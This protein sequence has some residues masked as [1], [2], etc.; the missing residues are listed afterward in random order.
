MDF[1]CLNLRAF[2]EIP[3]E[4][5]LRSSN[6]SRKARLSGS[7]FQTIKKSQA[8]CKSSLMRRLDMV[9]IKSDKDPVYS[10]KK[11]KAQFNSKCNLDLAMMWLSRTIPLSPM[12]NRIFQKKAMMIF[13]LLLMVF[14]VHGDLLPSKSF[15]KCLLLN[16]DT[17]TVGINGQFSHGYIFKC[18]APIANLAIMNSESC[19]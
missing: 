12:I 7:R 13:E 11:V 14:I 8:R 2:Y 6:H 9:Q 19:S 1:T 16:F 3:L 4:I 17:W 5:L 10:L 18:I 15:L